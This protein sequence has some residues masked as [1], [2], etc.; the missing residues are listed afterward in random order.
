MK[1]KTPPYDR[2]KITCLFTQADWELWE[3]LNQRQKDR[4]ERVQGQLNYNPSRWHRYRCIF[5]SRMFFFRQQLKFHLMTN[6]HKNKKLSWYSKKMENVVYE[7]DI[8]PYS[9]RIDQIS[10]KLPL[11][12]N[13]K[14]MRLPA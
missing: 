2:K 13:N 7:C 11:V 9:T 12:I 14:F 5:C 3:K 8:F 6:K 4:E 1:A 10:F